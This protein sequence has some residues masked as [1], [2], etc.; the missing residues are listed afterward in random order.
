MQHPACDAEGNRTLSAFLDPL[1]LRQ[2]AS[3]PRQ[4][5]LASICPRERGQKFGQVV[6]VFPDIRAP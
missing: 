1:V 3:L 5:P 4:R 6:D 2:I